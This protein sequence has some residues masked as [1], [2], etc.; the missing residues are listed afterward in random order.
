MAAKKLGTVKVLDKEYPVLF[1]LYA[2]QIVEDDFG[3]ILKMSENI[4]NGDIG[5]TQV[6]NLIHAMIVSGCKYKSILSGREIVPPTAEELALD[7]NSEEDVK[8]L[9]DAITP[10]MQSA[11]RR[12]VVA[13][14]IPSKKKAS[15][16]ARS[17]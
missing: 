17:R 9:V 14:E 12:K 4:N 13:S 16:R 3:G 1:S 15:C 7:I 6:I 8:R 5:L 10:M 2:L 11:S